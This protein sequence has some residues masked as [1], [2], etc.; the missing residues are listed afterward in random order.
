MHISVMTVVEN[1]SGSGGIQYSFT[2]KWTY[3]EDL[4]ISCKTTWCRAIKNK[5]YFY[6]INFN[7]KDQD[8]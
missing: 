3:L 2:P 4:F 1:H 7:T 5:A 6:Q 8:W